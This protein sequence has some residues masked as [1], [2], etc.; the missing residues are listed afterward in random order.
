MP[1]HPRR[2]LT[3][4]LRWISPLANKLERSSVSGEVANLHHIGANLV[5]QQAAVFR[6]VAT[7]SLEQKMRVEQTVDRLKKANGIGLNEYKKGVSNRAA[8]GLFAQ[9]LEA[10]KTYLDRIAELLTLSRA[11]Q[12]S[13][14]ITFALAREVPAYDRY[15]AALNASVLF[16]EAEQRKIA[17][18]ITGQS[19]QA[20]RKGEARYRLLVD[21]SPDGILVVCKGKIVFTNPALLKMLGTKRADQLIGRSSSEIVHPD[22]RR[23]IADR[24]SEVAAGGQ[25]PVAE[26]WMLRLDRNRC[27]DGLIGSSRQVAGGLP[28]GT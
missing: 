19:E 13:A 27:S 11:P 1:F 22:E 26:R 16:E 6:H 2:K 28:H 12:N 21:H 8:G 17:A 20:L 18:D 9:L 14:T 3:P 24:A 10:R 5:L 7:T 23:Q 15:Q 25:P 4:P